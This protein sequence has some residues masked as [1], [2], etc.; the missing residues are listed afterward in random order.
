MR[1]IK[2]KPVKGL[3]VRDP[4]TRIPLKGAGEEKPRNAYW[5]RRLNDQSVVEVKSKTNAKQESES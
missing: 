3:V 4:E 2:V 5:I 1:T